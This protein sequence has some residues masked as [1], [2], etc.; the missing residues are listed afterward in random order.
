MAV[1]ITIEDGRVPVHV[2]TT[3]IEGEARAQVAK[4]EIGRAS[5]RERV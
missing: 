5:W 3:D 4:L 2:W 1:Q